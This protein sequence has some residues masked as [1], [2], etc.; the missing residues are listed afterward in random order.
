[1]QR[2]TWCARDARCQLATP[3]ALAR[4]GWL[5]GL[6]RIRR[7]TNENGIEDELI[8]VLPDTKRLP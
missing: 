1:M 5:A 4:T 6:G 2:N 8:F 7:G 3:W